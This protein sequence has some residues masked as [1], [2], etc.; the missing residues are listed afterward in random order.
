MPSLP[1]GFYFRTSLTI[2]VWLRASEKC[3]MLDEVRSFFERSSND[4]VLFPFRPL[5][6]SIRPESQTNRFRRFKNW[7]TWLAY[8][9][10][11]NFLKD[12][13]STLFL[14]VLSLFPM[15]REASVWFLIKVLKTFFV[16]E[17]VRLF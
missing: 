12:L 2:E 14:E 15:K 8:M 13:P 17:G 16:P 6:S 10:S 5:Q 4:K 1:I 11:T 3:S 7:S 9:Y